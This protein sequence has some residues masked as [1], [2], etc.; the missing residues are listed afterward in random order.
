MPPPDNGGKGGNDVL[1][2][3]FVKEHLIKMQ[4]AA[5]MAASAALTAAAT[6]HMLSV[7]LDS[8]TEEVFC[9]ASVEAIGQWMQDVERQLQDAEIWCVGHLRL[10]SMSHCSSHF[11]A[12]NIAI[13]H[14]LWRRKSVRIR[15]Q[16]LS[17]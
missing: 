16:R 4:E 5:A 6:A 8:Q 10:C 3:K 7:D 13:F 12:G 15:L 11:F 14:V 9:V 17:N 1:E 2:Q